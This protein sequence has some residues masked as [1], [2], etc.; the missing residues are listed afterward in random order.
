MDTFMF[1]LLMLIAMLMLL[2]VMVSTRGQTQTP[3]VIVVPQQATESNLGCLV[4][5]LPALFLL[6]VAMIIYID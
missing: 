2:I 5:L 6:S 3:P 1:F 4:L